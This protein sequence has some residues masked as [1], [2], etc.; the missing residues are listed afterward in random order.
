[1]RR[2]FTLQNWNSG[3]LNLT[4][5]IMIIETFIELSDGNLMAMDIMGDFTYVETAGVY[6][7]YLHKTQHCDSENFISQEQAT[8]LNQTTNITILNAI[9]KAL[10][11]ARIKKV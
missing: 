4:E 8:D 2:V 10:E 6:R 11:K 7:S 9:N 5:L 3:E 1:M